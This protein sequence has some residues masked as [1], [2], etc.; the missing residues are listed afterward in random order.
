MRGREIRCKEEV[1]R[2]IKRGMEEK[3]NALLECGMLA[4]NAVVGR[5]K[6]SEGKGERGEEG[7]KVCS[8]VFRIAT[9][10]PLR[11]RGGEGMDV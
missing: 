8:P 5:G 2:R 6:Q 4:Y 1:E 7:E 9:G 3:W 10:P 11:V